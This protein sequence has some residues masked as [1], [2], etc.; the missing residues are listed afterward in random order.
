MDVGQGAAILGNILKLRG[1]LTAKNIAA[2]LRIPIRP[3][4]GRA[5]AA[6]L[7]TLHIL[8]TI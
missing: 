8:R 2:F 4:N 5:R 7:P 1:F 6:A 3:R